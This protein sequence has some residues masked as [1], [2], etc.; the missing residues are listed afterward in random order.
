MCS[1]KSRK[2]HRKTPV[3]E[4]QAC[5]FIKKETLAQAFSCEFCEISKNTFFIE[6]L[7]TTASQL[8]LQ[9]YVQIFSSFSEFLF[10]EYCTTERL[11]LNPVKVSQVRFH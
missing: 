8:Y 4:P 11:L 1:Q 5:N 3:P 9:F 7:W 10:S 2:I 6:H